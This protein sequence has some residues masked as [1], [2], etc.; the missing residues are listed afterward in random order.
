M[1]FLS[2]HRLVIYVAH[3]PIDL[4]VS[5]RG[6]SFCLLR[7]VNIMAAPLLTALPVPIPSLI[8]PTHIPQHVPSSPQF[9]NRWQ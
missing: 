6:Y 5:S 8:A 9:V 1:L 4:H 2:E 3:I 7:R